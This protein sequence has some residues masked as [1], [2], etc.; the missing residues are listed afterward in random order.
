[1]LS[2]NQRHLMI[3]FFSFLDFSVPI[4]SGQRRDCKIPQRQYILGAG[5]AQEH[6][7]IP[8]RG[9]SATSLADEHGTE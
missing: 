6:G 5:G 4:R 9:A 7:C 8:I 1:M 3:M 2:T